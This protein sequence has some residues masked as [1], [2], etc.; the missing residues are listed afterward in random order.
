MKLCPDNLVIRFSMPMVNQPAAGG[1]ANTS[2]VVTAGAT[3]PSAQQDNEC[4]NCRNCW[5]PKIKNISYG[6]H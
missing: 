3:C 4:K 2:T 1:W 5:D 6:K